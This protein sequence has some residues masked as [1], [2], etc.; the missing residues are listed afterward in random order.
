VPAG[1]LHGH[2]QRRIPVWGDPLN[3]G[4]QFAPSLCSI[5]RAPGLDVGYPAGVA[6]GGTTM[7]SDGQPPDLVGRTR[8]LAEIERALDEVASGASWAL[9]LCGEAGIGK[10]HL[11]AEACR[12]AEG[13]GFL[14]LDGRAAEFEQDMPFGLIVDALNDYV[15]SL[16]PTLWR[17]LDAETLDELVSILPSLSGLASERAVAPGGAQ[18]YRVHYAVRALLERLAKR[19]PVLLALDDL[20]WADAASV[21]VLA[22]ILRRFRGPLLVAVALRPAPIGLAAALESS[23][24]AGFGSRLELPPLSPEEAG[25][26]LGPEFDAV[27]Q[28]AVYRE[29]GGNPFYLE[30]LARSASR[31]PVHVAGGEARVRD[32]EIPPGVG[33]LVADELYR[34]AAEQKLVLDAAA[35]VGESFDAGLV[36]TVAERADVVA[37]T[38]LDELVDA[39]LVRPAA[40]PRSFRFRH[41]IVRRV[42]YDSMPAGWRAE[43]HARAAA[44]LSATGGAQAELAHHVARSATPG[45]ERAIALLEETARAA[46]PRAPLT[47]GRWLRAAAGLVPSEERGRP[48]R[49]LGDAGA[50][51]TSGGGYGEALEALEEALSIASSD[52]DD[53]RGSLVAKR[54]EARRRGGRAFDSRAQLERALR[55]V[56][57]LQAATAFALRLELAMNLYW[58]GELAAL[59]ALAGELLAT[60]RAEQDQLVVCLAAALGALA[61][62]DQGDFETAPELWSEAQTAFDALADERLA[63]RIYL[64][65][66]ICEAAIRLERSDDALRSFERG[67]EVARATGQD[68]TAGSWP[69]LAAQALLLKGEVPKALTIAEHALDATALSADDW[70]MTWLLS[71]VSL[72][73]FWG[74]DNARALAS[75]RDMVIHS[76]RTHPKTV[77]PRLAHLRLGS[78][79]FAAGDAAAAAEELRALDTEADRWLLDL[80]SCCGWDTLIR[81]ELTLGH[82]EAAERATERAE[83]RAA[84]PPQRAATVRCA[85]SALLLAQGDESMGGQVSEEA[86][87][88]AERAGNPVLSARCRMQRGLTLAS[89]GELERGIA[90]L[91]QAEQALWECGAARDADAAARE[92]RRL[93]QRVTRRPRTDH[94]TGLSA[95][96]PRE[97]DVADEV[98]AGKTNREIATSLFLSEKTVENH[99]SRIYSKLDVHSRAA[100]AALAAREGIAPDAENVPPKTIV[101]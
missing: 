96:S 16:G 76:E 17:G 67:T 55:S 32:P 100:L 59:A 94:R 20:H 21:E 58:H 5:S 30:Q 60:A 6:S 49:L 89:V 90:D 36:A 15:G 18:R 63:E 56:G 29:S 99:L 75:A 48:V 77:L 40:V 7:D 79:L 13:R 61:S 74:G 8:E 1:E 82:L 11:L 27:T 45:D 101:S 54:A 42:V 80:D 26:L 12:R 14:V 47:G 70:K 65:H 81:A 78:A 33:A 68:V 72:A 50:L 31:A 95:L 66:Y 97:R 64:T 34:L 44:G 22:H 98:V 35:V 39:D 84:Q 57:E 53:V 62:S 52:Q 88:L 28:E 93:G 51:L 37:L 9:E 91:R 46:A 92:L 23:A 43:A 83:S 41:P 3:S 4:A 86:V 2:S 24:R 69:G 19:Q 25:A 10:S 38:L 71:P 87:R 85:R 73:A